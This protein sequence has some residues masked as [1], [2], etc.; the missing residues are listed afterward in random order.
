MIARLPPWVLKCS[1]PPVGRR[2]SLTAWQ[3]R[4]PKFPCSDLL[5]I[6]PVRLR[7]V[8]NTNADGR[9]V[10]PHINAG[11][12]YIVAEQDYMYGKISNV[13]FYQAG[14][15]GFTADSLWQAAPGPSESPSPL[16]GAAGNFRFKDQQ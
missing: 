15:G 13:L 12:Y 11:E 1:T 9:V 8:A 5:V 16:N 4:G 3:L 2:L 6:I 7:Q 10:F 14:V